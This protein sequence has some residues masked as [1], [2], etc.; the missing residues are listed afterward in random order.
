MSN[1]FYDIFKTDTLSL[2]RSFVIKFSEVAEATNDGLVERGYKVDASDPAS[3]K[4]Y[5]NMAGLY[6]ESDVKMT[7][8][9]MDTQEEIEFTRENL[10]L[11]LATAKAFR[12]GTDD[13]KQLVR[14]Y[15][16]QVVLINGVITPVPFETAYAARDGE[17]LSY[18][19]DLI[20]SQEDD[21][22]Y[23]IQCWIDTFIVRWHNKAY[24]LV[25]DYYLP[26][27]LG[28]F[29]LSLPQ[30]V[31][32]LRMANCKTDKA[33]T[34]HIREYLASNGH[35]DSY[36]PYLSRTQLLWLYR[37]IRWL[38]RNSGKQETF[39][40]L[41]ER[42][43]T[44]RNI[45]I[46][47]YS[48]VQRY[49]NMPA[50]IQPDVM[51]KKEPVNVSDITTTVRYETVLEILEK[52]N[53]L[54]KGN[55]EEE[56]DALISIPKITRRDRFSALPTKL[57][58]S[59][60][61]D[62]SDSGIK[63][64]PDIMLA[65]WLYLASHNRYRAYMRVTNP[66][67]GE[68]LVLSVRDAFIL[69]YYVY[70]K[71]HKI[72]PVAVP[73]FNAVEVK[74]PVLPTLMELLKHRAKDYVEE[75]DVAGLRNIF[76]QPGEYISIEAFYEHCYQVFTEYD[77][78][79]TYI[80]QYEELYQY[81]NLT[82]LWK[83]HYINARCD[84]L[85]DKTYAKW[86]T[87]TGVDVEGLSDLD[88][89]TLAST[90]FS[91]ATGSSLHK[92][93]TFSDVQTAMLSLMSK[94]TSYSVQFLKTI[95]F[96]TFNYVGFPPLRPGNKSTHIASHVDLYIPSPEGLNSSA[97]VRPTIAVKSADLT[98]T[99]DVGIAEND[100]LQVDPGI[101]FKVETGNIGTVALNLN[102]TSILSATSELHFKEEPKNSAL[103]GFQEG[104]DT[105][106][107]DD[108]PLFLDNG[109]GTQTLTVGNNYRGFFG[110]V[111][112]YDF[113]ESKGIVNAVG[114]KE[115]TVNND[116]INWF[117]FAYRGEVLYIP[118]HDVLSNVS[119]KTLEDAG[120]I[121]SSMRATG[122]II[123]KGKY[124]YT[125]RLLS[126]VP[127]GTSI[128]AVAQDI[129]GKTSLAFNTRLMSDTGVLG[130]EWSDLVLSLAVDINDPGLDKFDISLT[131]DSYTLSDFG[132]DTTQTGASNQFWCRDKV[133]YETT[134]PEID[135]LIDQLGEAV[136]SAGYGTDP[137][138][139]TPSLT[140]LQPYPNADTT[141]LG[142]RPVLVLLKD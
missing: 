129:Q 95:S 104:K 55:S 20:E 91:I 101:D 100:Y 119:I 54:A 97:V 67:D 116:D 127:E 86:M 66:K 17:I 30:V 128:C 110:T 53:S 111:S 35:L 88:Y 134:K 131:G 3:W 42:L 78:A 70:M 28:M 84:L 52:E 71:A 106:P 135:N 93:I 62:R 58:E 13:Y 103:P 114:L 38:T 29:Y 14:L 56:A 47:S 64:L 5:M 125:L 21:L 140:H 57:L 15:P 136:L 137:F 24:T 8:R 45:P 50:N 98:P 19:T 9:S 60:A 81:L 4:Y 39:D 59:E 126:A 16:E 26:A 34:F 37:N 49:E 90:I 105:P 124:R 23:K 40:L 75:S 99:V 73:S 69:M 72:T 121:N 7:V 102:G 120:L 82:Q 33:H 63:L 76:E 123:T 79:W 51:L 32:N 139:H 65:E 94:L 122:K 11:H 117:K 68:L 141:L 107:V 10:A 83:R 118:S 43:L 27:F 77:K 36:V 44:A 22:I 96:S 41:V 46:Y 18:A 87:D 113:F 48:L 1:E 80:A 109:P 112:G 133:S 85:L 108:D 132:I 130:G 142:W 115:G 89:A 31:F 12:W 138:V 2:V 92:T 6:H 61:I 74:A 25:E